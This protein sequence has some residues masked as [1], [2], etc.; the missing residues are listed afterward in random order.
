MHRNCFRRR[1]SPLDFLVLRCSLPALLLILTGTSC[2]QVGVLTL[3]TASDGNRIISIGGMSADG[4]VIVGTMPFV[5][6]NPFKQSRSDLS[7]IQETEAF[8]WTAA[9]G[10]EPIGFIGRTDFNIS[11]AH[12]ISADGRVIIGESS[13]PDGAK[14]FRWT[15]FGGFVPLEAPSDPIEFVSPYGISGDGSVIVGLAI[16]KSNEEKAFRWTQF[17]G[18]QLL[19]DP[20]LENRLAAANLVSDNGQIVVGRIGIGPR[21]RTFRWT[22]VSGAVLITDST[23]NTPANRAF[24][25]SGDGSTIVGWFGQIGETSP[26]RWTQEEGIVS[27]GGLP[28]QRERGV[29]FA[30]SFDGSVIVGVT[31]AGSDSAAFIWDAVNGMRTVLSVLPEEDAALFEGWS[32]HSAQLISADGRTIAGVGTNPDGIQDIWV[33]RLPLF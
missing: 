30:T 13:S 26:F 24:D 29:A 14:P 10:I 33:V 6:E 1:F 15:R 23:D 7:F 21:T 18:Y 17:G 22:A 32:L 11:R 27:L 4:N 28:G 9:G 25:I 20:T 3:G 16:L 8:R 12:S 31:N 5:D 2:D 19:D